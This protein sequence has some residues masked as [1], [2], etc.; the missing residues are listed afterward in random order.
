M[1]ALLSWIDRWSVSSFW[2]NVELVCHSSASSPPNN[3]VLSPPAV[4][5]RS[6]DSAPLRTAMAP[7]ADCTDSGSMMLGLGASSRASLTPSLHAA[8]E[9][10][11]AI[12]AMDRVTD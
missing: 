5:E 8:S 3:Q 4:A 2:T 1:V 9:Q 11:A 7:A 12:A 6:P 10:A